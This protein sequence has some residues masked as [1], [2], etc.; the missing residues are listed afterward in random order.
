MILTFATPQ[1]MSN[2]L[3]ALFQAQLSTLPSGVASQIPV[4]A[5]VKIRKARHCFV[6]LNPIV[7]SLFIIKKPPVMQ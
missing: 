3:F 1:E 5:M 4:S 7:P 6:D 2:R